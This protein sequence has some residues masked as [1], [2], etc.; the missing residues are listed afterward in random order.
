MHCHRKR[1][2]DEQRPLYRAGAF[3]ECTR[4]GLLV[5]GQEVERIEDYTFDSCTALYSVDIP[6]GITYIGQR[7]FYNCANF[8]SSSSSAQSTE[9][10]LSDSEVTEIG[11]RAFYGCAGIQSLRLGEK[12]ETIG[13]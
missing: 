11:Q 6:D 3:R 13:N 2:R 9:V 10:D 4:L 5:L 7:A 1:Q 12:V 8:S